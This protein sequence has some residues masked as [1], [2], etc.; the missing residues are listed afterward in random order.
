[1]GSGKLAGGAG[2]AMGTPCQQFCE[3]RAPVCP[4]DDDSTCKPVGD[5]DTISGFE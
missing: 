5:D 1:M 3:L 2:G 4:D